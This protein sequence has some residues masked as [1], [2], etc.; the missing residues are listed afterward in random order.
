MPSAAAEPRAARIAAIVLAAGRSRRFGLANKLLARLDGEALWWKALDAVNASP[1]QPVIVVL[2]HQSARL[3]T[4]L[5]AW[6]RTRR[7]ARMP[8]AVINADYRSGMAS[9]LQ[10]GL[11]AVPTEC[12]GALICLADMPALRAPLLRRLCAAYRQGDDAVLPVIR[13][14]RGNPAL[15]GRPLFAAVLQ[16]LRGDQGAR[17]LIAK[18]A[19]VREVR[20]DASCLRDIDT[21]RQWTQRV[22]R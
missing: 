19:R 8:R 11:R 5:R 9:S 21:R 4:S 13:G 10:A 20:G 15:L 7:A 1:A 17:K 18:S 12:D 2:G 22:T 6:R 14:Q 16:D 3:R